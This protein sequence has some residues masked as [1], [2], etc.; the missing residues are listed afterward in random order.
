MTSGGVTTATTFVLPAAW[1]TRMRPGATCVRTAIF[2]EAGTAFCRG[3]V[4]RGLFS[5]DDLHPG[6]GQAWRCTR[7]SVQRLWLVQLDGRSDWVGVVQNLPA[8]CGGSEKWGFSWGLEGATGGLK[9]RSLLVLANGTGSQAATQTGGL[10]RAHGSSAFTCHWSPAL[11]IAPAGLS[12]LKP[13]SLK[14]NPKPGLVQQSPDRS[15]RLSS[16]ST[17]TVTPSLPGCALHSP[18]LTRPPPPPPA[19][20]K[21]PLASW[22]SR[23]RPI[24][25]AFHTEAIT[26]RVNILSP[27]APLGLG[28]MCQLS[29]RSLVIP[30]PC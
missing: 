29:T 10:A 12:S 16:R 22:P 11:L 4:P 30:W 25:R 18:N 7:G 8:A 9:E 19:P 15:P 6:E 14:K 27:L 26:G 2:P 28:P 13:A 17:S 20:V 24:F 1:A 21:L 3:A 5:L 23:E